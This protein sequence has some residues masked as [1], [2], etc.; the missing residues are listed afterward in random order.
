MYGNVPV[1]QMKWKNKYKDRLIRVARH[2]VIDEYKISNNL[3][4][5]EVTSVLPARLEP[6]F[7]ICPLII[8]IELRNEKREKKHVLVYYSWH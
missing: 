7:L 2:A 5:R 4:A 6:H 1:I 3:L 8:I